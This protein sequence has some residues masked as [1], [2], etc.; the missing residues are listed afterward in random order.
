MRINSNPNSRARDHR[1]TATATL[2][3]SWSG[4]A[5]RRTVRYAFRSTAVWLSTQQPAADR[6]RTTPS[7]SWSPEKE[8]G[9]TTANRGYCRGT[10]NRP[11]RVRHKLTKV[12]PMIRRRPIWNPPKRT[13]G[14]HLVRTVSS[15]DRLFV[16]I[17][18]DEFEGN[19]NVVASIVVQRFQKL[20]SVHP[21]HTPK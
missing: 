5:W 16:N 14:L 15:R 12:Y 19:R 1:T 18:D 13:Q 21:S 7:P 3:G 4:A 10:N 11:H 9:K 2:I 20:F 8:I 6:F 17:E